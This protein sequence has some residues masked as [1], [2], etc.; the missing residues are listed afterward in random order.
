MAWRSHSRRPSAYLFNN[1]FAFDSYSIA[2]DASQVVLLV[3]DLLTLAVPFVFAGLL[4]GGLLTA[5]AGDAGRI[6]AANLLGSAAGAIFAL[7]VMSSL[8]SAQTVLLCAA[9]GGL[10]GLV[11]AIERGRVARIACAAGAGVAIVLL[12]VF[13]PAFEV[14]TSP[15]KT[16]SQFRLNPE[17]EI[18]RTDENAY[19]RLDVVESATIHS[20]PGLSLGYLGDLPPQSGLIIDAGHLLPVAQAEATEVGLLEHLPSAVAY[21]IRPDADVLILG[22]GG[23]LEALTALGNTTGQV[24]V[25]EPN[26]L[27]YEALTTD[28]GAWAGLAAEPRVTLIHEDI[29]AAA[30]RLDETYD[31]VVLTLAAGYHPIS[32]GAFT[33]NED[34]TLT[35]EAFDSYFERLQ[36]DGLFV[37]HRWLQEPPSETVRT[38]A[39]ILGALEA[40]DPAD[41]IV[42]FRSFQHGTFMVKPSGYSQG[43]LDALL[44]EIDGLRYDLTLA[45]RM[46][47][48]MVN[49]YARLPVPVYRDTYVA[50]VDA[51]DRGAFFASQP[52][53]VTPPSD[54]RPFF[55]HFFRPEQTSDVLEGLGRR[56]QPFGGSG[57]FVLVALLAFAVAAALV[58]VLLPV[59]LRRRFRGALRQ[60]GSVRSARILGYFSL[61]GLAF[62]LVEISLIQQYILV[63]GQPTLGIATV[64]GALLL[65]SGLGSSLSGRFDWGRVMIV[66]VVLLAVYPVAVDA[67]TPLLLPLP[68]PLRILAT[69]LLIAPLGFLM[70][71]PFP[72]GVAALREHSDVVPWAWAANGS[73]SVISAVLAALLALSFGFTAVL[74]IGAGLY[75]GAA[76]IRW[77][78]E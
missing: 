2:W 49:R 63:L 77:S 6:Y 54:S 69:A 12:V 30:R 35:V 9:L 21:R 61:L 41:Q 19:S 60:L 68:L 33:L 53:D 59:L 76:V 64:I 72:R 29:R 75:L 36:P 20:A 48:E 45:P 65:F 70:G 66:L 28:L 15:Y 32:S 55:F 50:L 74:A 8:S 34:Y 78:P 16:L 71:M 67:L 37:V 58:F 10:A 73:A 46:P 26:E 57:Y 3:A 38:L 14:Q 18:V 22:S 7:V 47:D 31:V 1:H 40:G 42:A 4:I 17:A 39:T 23:G 56:W 5:A 25:I 51:P 44:G 11:L 27:V 52:F 62:L 13:P 43:E 24:T